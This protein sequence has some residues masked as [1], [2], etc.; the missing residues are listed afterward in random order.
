MPPGHQQPCV[1]KE[2]REKRYSTFLCS[3]QQFCRRTLFVK[4]SPQ[5]IVSLS[6]S[7]R[8]TGIFDLNEILLTTY[9]YT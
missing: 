7:H 2:N 3:H 1:P 6:I 5:Q 8:S 9:I 4:N